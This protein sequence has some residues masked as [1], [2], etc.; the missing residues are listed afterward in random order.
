M[1]PRVA[2][3]ILYDI[4][5]NKNIG[6]TSDRSKVLL[7]A[8]PEDSLPSFVGSNLWARDDVDSQLFVNHKLQ[9]VNKIVE[10][11]S[12]HSYSIEKLATQTTTLGGSYRCNLQQGFPFARHVRC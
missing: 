9:S 3:L 7:R 6:A 2:N 10:N 1:W 8:L 11:V 12:T 5:Y 4:I